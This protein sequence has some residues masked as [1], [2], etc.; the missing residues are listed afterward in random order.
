[1]EIMFWFVM[2]MAY[3]YMGLL[4]LN[5]CSAHVFMPIDRFIDRSICRGVVVISLWVVVIP[6]A[7][8]RRAVR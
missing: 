8:A 2:G 1:M 5:V 4:A 6:L 3:V 7:Y